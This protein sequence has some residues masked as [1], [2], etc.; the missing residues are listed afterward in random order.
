MADDVALALAVAGELRKSAHKLDPKSARALEAD[1][2]RIER[3]L[4]SN[5]DPYA[6]VMDVMQLQQQLQQSAGQAPDD[7]TQRPQAQQ[8]PPPQPLPD[9][10]APQQAAPSQPATP[11][12]AQTAQLGD[13][14]ATALEAVDFTGFV[15][16][17]ITGT[18]RA[19]VDASAAQ[20]K[21]YANL[22]SS[23]ATTL[24][25]FT[26]ENV[27]L[28][29]ARDHLA[30]QYPQDL[31]LKLPA[32]GTQE[33]PRVTVRP[34]RQ[35]ESP[36]WLKK[37][38]LAGEEL[39]DELVEGPLLEAAR[40]KVGEGRM[41]S[42][43]TMVLMGINRIVVNDGE[44]RAKVQFHAAAV[45]VM[46]AD[47]QA[48]QGGLLNRDAGEAGS[49]TQMMVSTLKANAQADSALKADLMGEVR[50]S[51]RTEVFPLER[52]AD[53]AAIQLISRH[54]KWRSDNAA[55]AG[56]G[57]AGNA[58]AGNAPA[59]NAPAPAVANA[60]AAAPAAPAGGK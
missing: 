15:S 9:S 59:A 4:Q 24:E 32:P 55:Q 56:A 29:Q 47:Y 13:R 46:R 21:E 42:L 36:D 49:M 44:V 45:D 51:F 5:G 38:N 58:A 40:K 12:P 17:L 57:P 39:T 53:S 8:A 3:K 7:G 41:S 26:G 25:D 35:G 2:R 27:S 34:E 60:P 1:L 30:Q 43:A 33:Q 28:N 10:P 31:L 11:P 20:M 23:I 37:Y 54:A 52:F 50:V 48:Q 19:I 6:R 16:K 22:V 14:M 18:F